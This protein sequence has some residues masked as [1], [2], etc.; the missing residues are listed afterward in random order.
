[1]SDMSY[2]QL[3][4]NRNRLFRRVFSVALKNEQLKNDLDKLDRM[5]NQIKC[6]KNNPEVIEWIANEASKFVEKA[7]QK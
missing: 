2:E 3:A 4:A 6:S 1:M 7:K 5:I